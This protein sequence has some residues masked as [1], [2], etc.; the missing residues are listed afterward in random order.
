MIDVHALLPWVLPPLLGAIIGYLTNSLAIR[1]LFRP[2]RRWRI[3][4]LPV[5]FTPGVIP[6]R[7]HEL[8]ESIAAMVSRELLTP[9][10][11]TRRFL[12]PRF[13]YALRR[14][15]GRTLRETAERRLSDP[16][17]EPRLERILELVRRGADSFLCSDE[18]AL[19]RLRSAASRGDN[20]PLLRAVLEIPIAAFEPIWSSPVLDEAIGGTLARFEQPLLEYFERR[21]VI[22][23]TDA[24]IRRLLHYSFDQLSTVQRLVVSA[25]QFDRQM[26]SRIPQLR[27]RLVAELQTLLTEPHIAA[28]ITRS[29][30]DVLTERRQEP[31]ERIF[32]DVDVAAVLT[33][34]GGDV[35]ATVLR[36]LV[37]AV[38][39][40]DG[41]D[42]AIAAIRAFLEDERSL[43][44][45]IP[46]LRRREGTISIVLAR[47]IRT[48]LLGRI[49]SL[50]SALNI[51]EVVVERIDSL[52]VE[53]V[54][55]LLLG[56]IRRHLRWINLFGA[57]IGAL[58][59]GVQ[60]ALRILGIG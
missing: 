12:S 43:G 41:V 9:E 34:A 40:R 59:G 26:E 18:T 24:R 48:I 46:V 4:G 45:M 17:E 23:E 51:R 42:R 38:R 50:V 49:D 37:T 31:L 3:L 22:R 32:G 1:M 19:N 54:E 30:R 7:R 56:I 52:E 55:A 44:E 27:R 16:A 2:L 14:T 39:C 10:V 25:G 58:I 53:R 29:I 13:G 11:F 35:V 47:S 20:A 21:E 60:I 57:L 36:H 6:R 5:P 15:I 28:A 8:A 33:A